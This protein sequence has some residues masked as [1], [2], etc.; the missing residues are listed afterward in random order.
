MNSPEAS[1][2]EAGII[3]SIL[4]VY[5]CN[6]SSTE[7]WVAEAYDWVTSIAHSLY[8]EDL[9]LANQMVTVLLMSSSGGLHK[10]YFHAAL[11]LA[12]CVAQQLGHIQT[13]EL[14]EATE[15]PLVNAKTV[16]A[17]VST[18]LEHLN[19]HLHEI[20]WIFNNRW[21]VVS[22]FYDFSSVTVFI[23]IFVEIANILSIFVEVFTY[24]Y[25]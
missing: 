1:Q 6:S 18:I 7:F 3:M 12:T 22:Q 21:D 25:H 2:K 8:V 20:D 23:N 13:N 9:L 4:A 10:N 17:I 5:L 11:L 16:F 19:E 15:L 24:Y 14:A